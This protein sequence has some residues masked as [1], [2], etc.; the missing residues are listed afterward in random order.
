LFHITRALASMNLDIHSAK[1]ASWAG[2]AEDAFYITRRENVAESGA[3]R[4]SKIAD[5]DIR[6]VL[7]ELR[8]R[9][10]KPELQTSNKT[11]RVLT[12]AS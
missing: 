8:L 6:A 2:R 11:V 5:D 10:R 1:V 7:D 12:S 3:Q 9:L 4:N